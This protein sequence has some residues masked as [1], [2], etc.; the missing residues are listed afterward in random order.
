MNELLPLR[1]IGSVLYPSDAPGD[2]QRD[3]CV[4]YWYKDPAAVP[5]EFA[6]RYGD[7]QVSGRRDWPADCP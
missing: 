6:D 4:W 1:W 2:Y 7:G 3:P 5:A